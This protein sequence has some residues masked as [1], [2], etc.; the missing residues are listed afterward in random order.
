ML[1]L[2][3]IETVGNGPA[4]IGGSLKRIETLW[5][6][7]ILS[8]EGLLGLDDVNKARLDDFDR[9]AMKLSERRK[10]YVRAIRPYS[11][12]LVRHMCDRFPPLR[13]LQAHTGQMAFKAA[14]YRVF[15]DEESEAFWIGSDKVA[16]L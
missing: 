16:D 11:Q 8:R 4:E 3:G 5:W 14:E 13:T 2:A 10:L 15:V 9:P 7:T 6:T 1:I 12:S